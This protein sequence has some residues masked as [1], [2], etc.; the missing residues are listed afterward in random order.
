MARK[1]PSFAA[2]PRLVYTKAMGVGQ[3]SRAELIQEMRRRGIRVTAQRLAVMELLADT[4]EH[5][6]AQ[7][8]YQRLQQRLPHITMGTVYNTLDALAKGGFVQPLPFPQGTRY[9]A[10]PE[11]H[12]NLLCR[13]CGA[14]VDVPDVDGT[15]QRLRE[16][17]ARAAHFRVESQRIDFYGVCAKCAAGSAPP[18]AAAQPNAPL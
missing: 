7:E 18:P 9:D 8:I 11:P 13:Q 4:D 16:T 2:D 3:L 10:N 1:K 12:A 15:V 6:T 14:I 5:L 17:V